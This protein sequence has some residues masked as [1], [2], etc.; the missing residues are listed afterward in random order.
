MEEKRKRSKEDLEEFCRHFSFD[1][2]PCVRQRTYMPGE[3]LFYLEE[4][5]VE[6]LYL[7]RGKVKLTFVESNGKSVIKI[8]NARGFLGDM[9]F[10]HVRAASTEAEA[11]EKCDVI[12]IDLASCRQLLENDPKFLLW[13][14]TSISREAYRNMHAYVR[15]LSWPLPNRMAQFILEMQYNGIYREKHTEASQYLGVSYGHFMAVIK[16]FV[17]EGLL[18]HTKSGYRIK[19]YQRLLELAADISS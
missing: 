11:Y 9:E 19:D 4:E 3:K 8:L 12:A 14:A 18:E 1:I 10:L 13:L 16:N 7:C 2:A 15:L 5:P 17:D 6:L